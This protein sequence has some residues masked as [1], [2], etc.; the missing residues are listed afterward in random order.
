MT[1][2]WLDQPVWRPVTCPVTNGSTGRIGAALERIIVLHDVETAPRY[3]QA[4]GLTRCNLYVGD[5]TRALACPI[6]LQWLKG[7]KWNEQSA[8]DMIRWLRIEG[9]KHGWSMSIPLAAQAKASLG[10]PAVVGWLNPEKNS[11]GTEK[12]GHI[13]IFRPDNGR[14][15]LFVASAGAH[16]SSDMTLSQSFGDREVECWV[17][18]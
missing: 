13:S 15:G 17:H 2:Q 4:D 12:S 8:N 14:Q 11:D 16:N 3:Q 5:V 7:A 18:A 6:P 9:A 1:P 10:H